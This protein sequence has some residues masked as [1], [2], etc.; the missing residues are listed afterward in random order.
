MYGKRGAT[1][2]C[3][4]RYSVPTP[5]GTVAR[6]LLLNLPFP[7]ERQLQRGFDL[8]Q[9]RPDYAER[10]REQEFCE[11]KPCSPHAK[12]RSEPLCNQRGTG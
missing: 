12:R 1:H 3:A 9:A 8:S 6:N 11:R 10:Q 2:G 7:A 4:G 5:I